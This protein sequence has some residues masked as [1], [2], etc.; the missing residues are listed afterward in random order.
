MRKSNR[1]LLEV[2]VKPALAHLVIPIVMGRTK[3]QDTSM[4]KGIQG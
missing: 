2:T 1:L 3:K 4:E